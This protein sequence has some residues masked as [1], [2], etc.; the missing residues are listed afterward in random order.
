M[1]STASLMDNPDLGDGPGCGG[2]GAFIS[3]KT[4]FR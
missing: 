1:P 4:I 2:Y 3:G